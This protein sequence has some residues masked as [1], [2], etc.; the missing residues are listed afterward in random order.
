MNQHGNAFIIK[1][2]VKLASDFIPRY[3]DHNSFSSSLVNS[4]SMGS[5]KYSLQRMQRS[6]TVNITFDFIMNSF[7]R[8]V[9]IYYVTSTPNSMPMPGIAYKATKTERAK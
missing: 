6:L 9:R 4:T 8:V 1:D 7:K 2:P 3:F 5:V